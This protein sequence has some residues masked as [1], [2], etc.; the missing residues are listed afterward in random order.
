M[1]AKFCVFNP[2][3]SPLMVQPG[4][5]TELLPNQLLTA[6]ITTTESFSSDMLDHVAPLTGGAIRRKSHGP[7]L[8]ACFGPAKAWSR[9]LS[10]TNTELGNPSFQLVSDLRARTIVR[11]CRKQPGRA[12]VWISHFRGANFMKLPE[13]LSTETKSCH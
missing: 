12:W 9:S 5:R 3:R 6:V 13:D 7:S 10:K 8:P 4:C 11:K 2:R 1:P